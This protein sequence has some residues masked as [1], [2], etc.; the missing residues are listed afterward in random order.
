MYCKYT[1]YEKIKTTSSSGT[2]KTIYNND[3]YLLL[4]EKNITKF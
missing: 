3:S 2:S 4:F 1:N